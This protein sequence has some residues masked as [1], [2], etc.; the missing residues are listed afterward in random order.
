MGSARLRVDQLRKAKLLGD[1]TI[2]IHRGAGAYICGEETALL[3]SLEGKRGQPRTSRRSR[4]RRPLRLS[5]S[6]EQRRVDRDG[7]ADHRDGRGGV[8]E[9]RAG[10]LDGTRVFSLSG[11]VVRPGNY[12][13]P[14]GFPLRDLI[15]EVGGGIAEGAR[16]RR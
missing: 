16:S 12:E 15:Y 9:A 2:V 3:E 14:H 8:R 5:D 7:A 10:E 11:N 6:G 1:V 13:L 4:D